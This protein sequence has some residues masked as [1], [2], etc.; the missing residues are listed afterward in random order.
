M[1]NWPSAPMADDAL[2]LLHT[3]LGL[4]GSGRVRYGAAMALYVGGQISE[5]QLDAFRDASPFDA[6]DPALLLADRGLPALPP[7]GGQRWQSLA[8]FSPRSP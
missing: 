3:P 7:G 4:P 5:G 8:A 1:S 6:R 2:Q